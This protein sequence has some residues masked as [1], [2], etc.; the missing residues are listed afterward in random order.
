M[1]RNAS[2]N[3]S[4]VLLLVDRQSQY[5]VTLAQNIHAVGLQVA[6]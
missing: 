2:T 5:W 4:N 1:A 3:S 6:F